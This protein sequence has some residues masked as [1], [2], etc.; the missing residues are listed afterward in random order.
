MIEQPFKVKST[1]SNLTFVDNRKVKVDIFTRNYNAIVSRGFI[2]EETTKDEMYAKILEE[3][4]EFDEELNLTT[5]NLS[6]RE[7]EELT[8]IINVCCN[9]LKMCGRNPFNELKKC[10]ITQERRSIKHNKNQDGK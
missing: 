8:D 9:L 3:L 4:R 10:A 5:K 7:A 2:T 1:K 6:N